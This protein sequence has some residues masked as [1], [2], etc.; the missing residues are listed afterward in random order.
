MTRRAASRGGLHA[1][2]TIA[3]DRRRAIAL[4]VLTLS[5]LVAPRAGE[6]QPATKVYRL[7]II[8]TANTPDSR[9]PRTAATLIPAAIRELGYV[10]GRNLVIERRFAGSRTELLPG[11]ARDL[12][13]RRMD[14][15]VAIALPAT[16]AAKQATGTIPIVMYGNFD[17]IGEGVAANLARPGG[18]VTGVMIAP[19]GTLAAK[20]LE[21]LKEAVPHATR[22]ALLMPDGLEAQERQVQEVQDAAVALGVKIDVVTVRRGD[23]AQA[24]A[25]IVAQRPGALFVAATSRF[26]RDRK[27]IIALVARHRLPAMY[28]WPEQVEDGGLMAYGSSLAGTTQRVAAYVD[29]IFKGARPEEL[30]IEQP[31]QF[32][33]AINVATARSLGLTIAPSLLLRADQLVE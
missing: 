12:V 32:R 10:E 3:A 2:S 14:V 6:P 24:F 31:T 21:L 16:R 22:I 13:Q 23:Y 18:N 28:E 25:E 11:M 8:S 33:L 26:M 29:R 4:V 9:D 17:P 7:G 1:W 20:K 30:P 27:Q 15:I 19:A 5:A